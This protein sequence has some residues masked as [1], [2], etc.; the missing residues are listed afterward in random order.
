M[1]S[2]DNVTADAFSR[3][4]ASL[5]DLAQAGIDWV[6][7]QRAVL[8]YREEERERWHDL[9]DELSGRHLDP[10][11]AE[12]LRTAHAGSDAT[13]LSVLVQAALLRSIL[14]MGRDWQGLLRRISPDLKRAADLYQSDPDP[15][16]SK[17]EALITQLRIF[18]QQV[19]E[20]ARDQGTEVNQEMSE[21]ADEILARSDRRPLSRP[22]R[23]MSPR[24]SDDSDTRRT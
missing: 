5:F 16:P 11:P 21:I 24:A 12:L 6:S 1:A 23:P 3:A 9:H 8:A 20:F 22:I 17:R 19:G 2:D 15:S 13:V 14:R 10:G 7:V 4:I 18:M